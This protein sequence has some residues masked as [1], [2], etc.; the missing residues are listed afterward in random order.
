VRPPWHGD[1]GLT[2]GDGEAYELDERCQRCMSTQILATRV[3]S[4]RGYDVRL[5]DGDAPQ[6]LGGNRRDD[7]MARPDSGH[8]EAPPT[9]RNHRAR[10]ISL[11][12]LYAHR[13]P[14]DYSDLTKH[15]PIGFDW[16]HEC[17]CFPQAKR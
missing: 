7:R 11:T 8:S 4:S 10:S 13:N 3:E 2:A 12:S 14:V 16:P 17:P 6:A 15:R 5:N 1:I 9:C